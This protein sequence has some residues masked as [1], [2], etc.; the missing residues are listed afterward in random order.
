MTLNA[1]CA[2]ADVSYIAENKED[3]YKKYKS[4]SEIIFCDGKYEHHVDRDGL[5]SIYNITDARYIAFADQEMRVYLG[6]HK[7][8]SDYLYG[9]II[10]AIETLREKLG[11]IRELSEGKKENDT[12]NDEAPIV[13]KP[14][15]LQV[16]GDSDLIDINNMKCSECGNTNFENA[17][18][19]NEIHDIECFCS[20]CG[21]VFVLSPSRYYI[22]KAKISRINNIANENGISVNIAPYDRGRI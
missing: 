13:V 4:S 21:T 11:I 19:Y 10:N 15:S 20:K 14:N 12:D 8:I 17:F 9:D 3:L 22:L 5:I 16:I 2:L 18:R 7:Y 1:L 6:V